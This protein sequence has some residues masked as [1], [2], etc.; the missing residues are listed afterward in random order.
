MLLLGE[1]P[2]WSQSF[3]PFFYILVEGLSLVSNFNLDHLAIQSV[4]S[5]A[6]DPSH[7]PAATPNMNIDWSSRCVV[8]NSSG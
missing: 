4:H 5:T 3:G 7:S 1:K 8:V 6:V 2:S